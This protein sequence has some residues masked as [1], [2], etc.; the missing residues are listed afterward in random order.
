MCKQTFASRNLEGSCW[1][2]LTEPA[3]PEVWPVL[4]LLSGHTEGDIAG[5]CGY[6]VVCFTKGQALA[7][8]HALALLSS[9]ALLDVFLTNSGYQTG[10]SPLRSGAE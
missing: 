8:C 1:A 10:R 5:P 3:H 9:L 2:D 6:G 4:V 7:L